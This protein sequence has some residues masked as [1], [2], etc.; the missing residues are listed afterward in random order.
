MKTKSVHVL[1]VLCTVMI[2]LSC[3]KENNAVSANLHL[4]TADSWTYDQFGIDQNLDGLIDVPETLQ[5]CVKDDVVT[6]NVNGS[7]N[8]DQGANLCYPEFPQSQPFD[9][10]FHNNETQIEYGGA[11]HTILEL[12]EDELAIYTEENDGSSTVRHILVYK[13]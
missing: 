7:G 10:Q 1:L 2:F 13:H 12:S 9:W 8:F 6:F 11:T 5:N 4:L 3:R